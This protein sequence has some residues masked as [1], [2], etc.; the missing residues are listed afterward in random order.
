MYSVSADYLAA[1]AEN[2]RASK[3]RGTIN[4]TPFDGRH[5]IRGTFA[6]NNQLCEATAIT[7]GGVYIGSLNMV[8]AAEFAEAMNIRGSWRGVSISAEIGVELEDETFEFVP[9]PGGSYTVEEAE[10]TDAGLKITAF[11]NMA[12]FDH[13][14]FAS[15][16][17]GTIYDFLSLACTRCGVSLGMSSAECEALINGT[18]TLGI[19]PTDSLE[20]FRDMLTQL[21]TVCAC[22]CTIDRQGRLVLRP[23]PSAPD[24]I[25][26]TVPAKLRYSTTFSDFSSFYDTITV[27]NMEDETVTA[28]SNDN[29]GG[30]TMNLGSNPFLQYGT[31][32]TK[33]RIRQNIADALEDFR[34]TPFTVSLLPNPALDLGDLLEFTGGIGQGALGA[35]MSY[36]M[37]VEK[38]TIEGY[39]ENPALADA[40]SKTDKEISGLIGKIGENEVIIYTFVNAQQITLGDETETDVIQIKFATVSPKIVQLLHEIDLDVTAVDPSEPIVC[41]VHYY[42]NGEELSYNPVTTWDND[43]LHLLHLMYFLATLENGR[44]YDWT[45]ALELSNATGFI[46]RDNA[47]ASLFG[48]GLV[49]A[50]SWEGDV[51]VSDASY[52]LTLGGDL[53]FNYADSISEQDYRT[54]D[55]PDWD[56]VHTFEPVPTVQ[57]GSYVLTLGGDLLFSYTEGQVKAE[58]FN[59]LSGYITEDGDA[60]ADEAGAWFITENEEEES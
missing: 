40:R 11:D 29:T 54:I 7:L 50:G 55:D 53:T 16:S 24:D 60:L 51:S 23:L 32:E 18:E 27:V 3:L 47:R 49:A 17:S 42:L 30:L 20:T 52:V 9:I 31:D 34:A 12:K 19:Y 38:T 59:E 57:D 6:V 1:M 46:D 45:V 8:L 48:Q 15:Q 37:K 26:A 44:R 56:G 22:F 58:T 4:G 21:A 41:T 39:G 5:V 28:Y 25:V 10:W 36:T 43:G 14:F 2:A 13:A 35:V 33:T